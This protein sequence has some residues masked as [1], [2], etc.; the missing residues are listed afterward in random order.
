MRIKILFFFLCSLLCAHANEFY[1][2]G[3]RSFDEYH[4]PY[5]PELKVTYKTG[6]ILF[7]DDV[8]KRHYPMDHINN[9]ILPLYDFFQTYLSQTLD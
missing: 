1:K 4:G 6:E 3:E 8:Y 9:D 7:E 2:T 5:N